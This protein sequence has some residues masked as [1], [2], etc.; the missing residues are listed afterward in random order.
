M[1]GTTQRE[2]GRFIKF[3][4]K[5]G[6]YVQ[7]P[8]PH[9]AAKKARKKAGR[10]TAVEAAR[11]EERVVG[12]VAAGVPVKAAVVAAGYA[13]SS[14]GE[15]MARAAVRESL[16]ETRE[17]LSQVEGFRFV[18]SAKFY[19]DKSVDGNVEAKDQIASRSRLDKLLGYESAAKVEI[20]ERRDL[21]VVV[22]LLSDVSVNPADLLG[23]LKAGCA[24][25]ID[26]D[27]ADGNAG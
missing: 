2:N 11:A 9:A 8:D 5:E 20:S 4:E 25:E 3:S 22:N 18:D 1:A 6:H 10:R 14:A 24:R 23:K 13:E 15:V 17:R 7:V 27:P 12:M 19:R 21:S 26:Y 16:A